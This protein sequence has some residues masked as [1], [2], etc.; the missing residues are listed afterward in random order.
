M[1]ECQVAF[2]SLKAY[3]QEVSRLTSPKASAELLMYLAASPMALRYSEIE[4]LS[5]ALVMASRKLR[6]HFQVHKI[7]VPLQYPI[8]EVL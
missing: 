3:F 2:E 8:G 1:A 6:H 7:I 4:K 5:Y